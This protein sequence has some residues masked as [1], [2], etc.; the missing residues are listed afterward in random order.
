MQARWANGFD[1]SSQ[2]GLEAEELGM[3]AIFT[4][5]SEDSEQD[6][7]VATILLG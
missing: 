3:A 2:A 4:V 7:F 5:H 6:T 1:V